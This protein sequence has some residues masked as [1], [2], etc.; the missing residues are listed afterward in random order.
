MEGSEAA[1][2][3]LLGTFE[4]AFARLLDF[5]LAGSGRDQ[6]AAGLRVTFQGSYAV[7]YKANKSELVIV[8]LLHGARDSAAIGE[9]GGFK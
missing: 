3:R 7:Y 1:A 4:T 6:L 2:T 5:P 8:R 9:R